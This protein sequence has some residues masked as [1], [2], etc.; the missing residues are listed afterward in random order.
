MTLPRNGFGHRARWAAVATVGL[1]ALALSAC[2]S[3]SASSS[4]SGKSTNSASPVVKKEA[5]AV[6][7]DAPPLPPDMELAFSD[8][9][10]GPSGAP[11]DPQ[12]WTPKVGPLDSNGELQYYTN[13]KNAALDGNGHLVLTA[14]R[15]ATPG[16]TCLQSNTSTRTGECQYTSARLSTKRACPEA[17]KTVD[18]SGKEKCSVYPGYLF[19]Q[20]GGRFEARIKLPAGQGVVPAFW[21]L[22]A[23]K[24]KWPTQ[25]EIDILE[26]IGEQ[27]KTYAFIKSHDWFPG[28]TSG[29]NIFSIWNQHKDF[30][31]EFHT[32]TFDQDPETGV[33][34]WYID[35]E[36]LWEQRRENAP[37]EKAA[38]I[39]NQPWYLLL[40]IAVGGNWPGDPRAD[41]TF[42]KTMTV[43]WVRVYKKKP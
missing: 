5:G 29:S 14:R 12:K 28:A 19:S 35:G 27:N 11:P 42:P 7:Q 39:F 8:D 10:D 30:T 4:E 16:T 23:N 13:N 18:A 20:R 33:M 32:F 21:L 41:S 31:G 9:F 25:G 1:S 6:G 15:E 40:N 37:N 36:K 3:S 38:A 34:T 2:G 26:A 17:D 22:G 24:E 43:D